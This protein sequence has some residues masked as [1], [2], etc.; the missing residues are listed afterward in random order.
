VHTGLLE[1]VFRPG[2]SRNCAQ[3]RFSRL[4]RRPCTPSPGPLARSHRVEYVPLSGAHL[5][6][7]RPVHPSS[8]ASAR[9]SFRLLLT[10]S[11]RSVAQQRAKA[12]AEGSVQDQTGEAQLGI[13]MSQSRFA[14]VELSVPLHFIR[15][16]RPDDFDLRL[17]HRHQVGSPNFSVLLSW[18]GPNH[19]E[20]ARPARPPPR[21]RLP[22]VP[23]SF[24]RWVCVVA[25][26]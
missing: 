21:V 8:V 5:P 14:T 12:L 11:Q 16:R 2:G 1:L 19:L 26:C 6:L 9:D 25:S 4:L 7:C 24:F 13:W 17:S 22:L 18:T 10:M 20:S 23:S 15:R 3:S